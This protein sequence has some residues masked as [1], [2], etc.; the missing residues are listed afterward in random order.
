[1]YTQPVETPADFQ[2]RASVDAMYTQI[3][4]DLTDAVSKLPATYPTDQ[5]GRATKWAAYALL[6]RVQMQKGDYGAAR[7]A[8]LEVKNNG[9]FQLMPNYLDN[10]LEETEFNKE[11]IFEVVYF[12]RAAN[13]FN[14]GGNGDD[15]TQPQ[16]TV[17][18]QEYSPIAWRNL[19]PS[20]KFLNEFE[21]TTKGDTK[22]DPRFDMSVYKTGD[23]FNNNI[24]TLTDAMQ[25]GNSSVIEGDTVKISWRKF[26]MIYKHGIGSDRAGGGIN[27]R[28]IRYSE[29][30]LMLAECE[31]ELNNIPAA[32]GYLNDVRD[33]TSVQMPHYPTANWPTTTKDQVTRAIMHERSV[34]LGGEEVRNR[35]I[36][37]WRKKGYYPSVVKEPLYYFRANRD[38]LLPIPQQEIDNNPKLGEGGIQPQNQGY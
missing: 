11:S 36:L 29:V 19:I 16:G 17:R 18:N 5:N 26:M 33:R 37:R 38:E 3:I 21:R 12:E 9:G 22:S 20:N 13:T 23:K 25:N 31:N 24:L 30:L 6:G 35:D 27:Q 15:P 2:P 7:T 34:E 1:M 32:V 8:L 4:A 14:W 28:M 10:F